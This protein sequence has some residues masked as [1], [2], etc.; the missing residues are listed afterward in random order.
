MTSLWRRSALFTLAGTLGAFNLGGCAA[1]LLGGAVV[2]GTLVASDRRSSATQLEDQLIDGK[3]GSRIGELLGERGK[4]TVTS[5]NRLVLLTGDVATESDKAAVEQAVSRVDGVRFVVNE[6]AVMGSAS[7]SMRS[8]DALLSAK[9]KASIV[10]TK[11]LYANSIKVVTERG[12]VYLLGRVTEREATQAANVA[13]G[14]SGVV[15]VVRVFDLLSEAEL[16]AIQPK[17]AT[18]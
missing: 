6:L 7:L 12:I 5:Y 2:G 18:K 10:D 4:V 9:V 17:A 15:K 16:E 13:R 14:V 1:L 3:A 11:G 8:N